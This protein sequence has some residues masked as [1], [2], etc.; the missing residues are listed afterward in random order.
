MTKKFDFVNFPT[1]YNGKYINGYIIGPEICELHIT[2][3]E[4]TDICV[5]IDRDDFDR[6]KNYFWTFC[7]TGRNRDCINIYTYPQ[8]NK[9]R[10]L[11]KHFILKETKER[12]VVKNRETTDYRKSNLIPGHNVYGTGQRKSLNRNASG[13]NCIYPI[14]DKQKNI[15]A[16]IL[17]YKEKDKSIKT[18]YFGKQKHGS[19]EEC[20][21]AAIKMRKNTNNLRFK[22][23]F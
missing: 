12:I 20:L 5:L 15:R 23:N 4:K 6:I 11:L 17:K 2:D 14:Y 9:Q 8:N 21:Q 3:Q 10:I 1:A 16:Y 7:K 19:L 22:N 18:I 13:E